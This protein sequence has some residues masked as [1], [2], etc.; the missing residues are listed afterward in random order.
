[1]LYFLFTLHNS[2]YMTVALINIVFTLRS[3]L[4]EQVPLGHCWA[5]GGDKMKMIESLKV[6]KA[7]AERGT[8]H[9]IFHFIGWNKSLGQAWCK[10][11]VDVSSFH[12][13]HLAILV[14][15][16]TDFENTCIR[17]AQLE[18]HSGLEWQRK[19]W[20]PQDSTELD[21]IQILDF[22]SNLL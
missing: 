19:E 2:C 18:N 12:R 14:L 9:C 15:C 13:E 5:H 17:N 6:F 21:H 22:S 3:K 1:M 4:K 8:K 20:G 10:Y 7:F 16:G 11:R